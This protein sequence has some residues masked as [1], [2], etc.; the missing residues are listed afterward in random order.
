MLADIYTSPEDASPEPLTDAPEDQ[1]LIAAAASAQRQEAAL[2]QL[3]TSLAAADVSDRA[4]AAAAASAANA[5]AT[6]ALV[7]QLTALRHT[8]AAAHL[9][10][11]GAPSTLATAIH[12]S[13]RGPQQPAPPRAFGED[14]PLSFGE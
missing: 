8:I 9:E 2:A 13:A 11:E 1:V 3:E 14:G 5:W 7:E 6:L 10:S 4:A 12:A